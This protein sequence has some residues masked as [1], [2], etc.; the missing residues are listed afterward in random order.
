MSTIFSGIKPSGDL[1]LGNYI[2]AI[3]N[4]LKLQQEHH[5]LFCVVDLHAITVPQEKLELKKRIKDIAALYLACG[6]DPNK[7]TI[8]VQSEVSA[9]AELSWILECNS[10][11]GELNRMTQ[12]KDKVQKSNQEE[13]ITSGLHTYPVLMA[14]DILLYDSN[15]VPVGDDQKQHIELTRDIATRFNNKYGETFMIPEHY[16]P[17]VGARIMDLQDPTKKM[18]KSEMDKGCILLLDPPNII[19]KKIMS[20]IT[21]SDTS[22]CY[23]KENKPGISNLLTIYSVLSNKSIEE[24]EHQYKDKMYGDFKK[25]LA[26]LVVNFVTPIQERFKDIRKSAE[27]DQILDDGANKASYLAN[28]KLMKVKKRIGLLRK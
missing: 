11:M 14:A 8:F 18:S 6:I 22:I 10:Y 20:A 16:I 17:K 27:L 1:T 15:L 19:K 4:F 2:G 3:S 5:C 26:D 13:S 24:L 28:K 23:D 21:D 9:H 7:A 12:Y 25:D